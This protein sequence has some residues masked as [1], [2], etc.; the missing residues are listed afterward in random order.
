M[1]ID[2]KESLTLNTYNVRSVEF[3]AKTELRA[4]ALAVDIVEVIAAARSDPRVNAVQVELVHPGESTRVT[5]IKDVIEPRVK[6]SGPGQVYPGVAGRPVT[7]VGVGETNRLAGVAVTALSPIKSYELASPAGGVV[8]GATGPG[9]NLFDMSGPG[10]D[11]SPYGAL[12]HIC[13][14][15]GVS[16]VLH[17][18]DQN[19]TIHAAALR[20]ADLLANTTLDAPADETEVFGNR[21]MNADVP[22]VVYVACMNSPQHYANSLNAYGVA[23]YGLT[24]QTPPW[25][26]RPTEILDGAIFGPNEPLRFLQLRDD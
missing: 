21:P 20:V 18:D 7:S 11:A 16:P 17:L 13:L 15:L 8:G 26:L 14:S 9:S 5:A 10:A 2:P 6:I 24:R 19:E 1:N 23:I 12:H 4:G 22:S 25:V 3:G